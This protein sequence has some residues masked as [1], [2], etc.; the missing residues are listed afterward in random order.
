ML[1]SCRSSLDILD[2]NPL[3][4]RWFANTFSYS[5][6]C[7]FSVL[8]VSF[9]VRIQLLPA[10]EKNV[11]QE[12]EQDE[13]HCSAQFTPVNFSNPVSILD[14]SDPQSYC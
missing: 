4:D 9:V 1:L 12:D 3:S 5:I 7:L 13:A 2:I 10:L 11:S 14:S 6:G 8:T